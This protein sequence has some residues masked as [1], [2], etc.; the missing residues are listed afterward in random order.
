[1][2]A[3][4]VVVFFPLIEARYIFLAVVGLGPLAKSSVRHHT[5]SL[6]NPLS[7][8]D[9]QLGVLSKNSFPSDEIKLAQDPEVS[10]PDT[11]LN[12]LNSGS[13]AARI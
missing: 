11:K 4:L 12:I 8:G 2:G 1:V 7:N 3:A 5:E 6:S 13:K 9:T 10:A